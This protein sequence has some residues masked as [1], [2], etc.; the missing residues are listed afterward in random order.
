M[1]IMSD[2][3]VFFLCIPMHTI[4]MML[5]PLPLDALTGAGLAPRADACHTL[6]HV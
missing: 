2:V 5:S 6:L 4:I 3:T 1:A